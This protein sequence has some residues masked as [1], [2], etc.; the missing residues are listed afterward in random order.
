MLYR[1]KLDVFIRIYDE[2]GYIINK[3]THKSRIT[4]KSGAIFLKAISRQPKDLTEIVNEIAEAFVTVD[5]D[6]LKK[7]VVEFL[8]ILE[9]DGFLVSGNT[10]EELDKNDIRFSYSILGNEVSTENFSQDIFRTNQDIED[11]LSKYFEN[12]P[13]LTQFHVELT[14]RCNERCVHCYIPHENKDTDID[15]NLYYSLLEQCKEMG[16]LG[17]TLSGGEPMSHPNF[18]DFL[19]K[20]K[21]YDFSVNVLTNLT[22]LTDEI[23]GELK[24][25]SLSGIQTSLYSM[26]PEIHDSITKVPGSF[27]KTRNAILKLIKNDIPL[28]ISCP[29]TRLN[30]DSFVDVTKWAAK[31][32]VPTV[33]DY[34]MMARFDHTT[35][36]LEYRL[37]FEEIENIIRS[38]INI[39]LE[40]RRKIVKADFARELKR[41]ISEDHLCKACTSSI[42]MNS[43]GMIY[44]CA[45]WQNYDCGNLKDT[46]LYEIWNHSP[47]VLYIRNLRK[48]DF[49]DCVKCPNRHFCVICMA[50][51]AN[52]DPN[53]N[54]L[55]VSGYS[56]KV[57]EINREI[58]LAIHNESNQ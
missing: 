42:S 30:K 21:E 19:H 13:I 29:I 41:D 37:T 38:N 56:C 8:D 2:V 50:R 4:D 52:E 1:Q 26:Q 6:T 58:A 54:P 15:P 24:S 40:Y 35:S 14:S 51:N 45:G 20:A 9:K 23:I 32:N 16:V 39:N 12:T 11:K 5:L 25:I 55:K 49:F 33:T 22:L 31:Y 53:G 48:K 43:H 17:I 3:G 10:L 36:N 57:A 7:D 27:F 47:R 44:P 34:I 28:Q 46:S 18:I